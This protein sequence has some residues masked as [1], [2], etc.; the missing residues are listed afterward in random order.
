MARSEASS[1]EV[2]RFIRQHVVPPGMTVTEAAR[3]LG[4]GRSALSNLLNGRAALSQDMALRLEGTFSAPTGRDC[5]SFRPCPTATAEVP[6]IGPSPS[7]P[8]RRTSSRSR[9][10]RSPTGRRGTSR[11]ASV[12]LCS[13][14]G[15]STRPDASSATWTFPATTTLSVTVGTGGS[16]QTRRRRGSRK[17]GQAGSSASTS[18][19]V[20]RPSATTRRA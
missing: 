1:T 7:A 16:K 8:T 12:C 5:W 6:K 20:P 11:R 10:G 15:W 4:V 17:A 9:R 3:R 18:V 13:S 2:G 14:A 19:R